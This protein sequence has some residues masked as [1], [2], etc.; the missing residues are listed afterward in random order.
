M[1]GCHA[2]QSPPRMPEQGVH[3]SVLPMHFADRNN[4]SADTGGGACPPTTAPPPTDPTD[5]ILNSDNPQV[6]R[7]LDAIR[8]QQAQGDP[9]WPAPITQAGRSTTSAP[10][11][12]WQHPVYNALSHQEQPLGDAHWNA[13]D[14]LPGPSTA[15]APLQRRPPPMF[16]SHSGPP[17][18]PIVMPTAALHPQAQYDS[19]HLDY[20][21][22]TYAAWNQSV[23][24]QQP[25]TSTRS[26]THPGL[27]DDN[28]LQVHQQRQAAAWQ[29]V[30]FN[31]RY[32]SV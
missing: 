6:R 31:Y 30:C 28:S 32:C 23:Q 2:R 5:D 22:A 19:G 18:D 27:L 17:S 16:T 24:G 8:R 11:L 12:R 29:P 26:A 14:T 21:H 10:D 15:S 4:T 1:Q 25:F 3:P 7:V 20:S 9:H 13:Q